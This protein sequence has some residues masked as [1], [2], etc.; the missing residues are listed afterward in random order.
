M[1][2]LE[3]LVCPKCHEPLTTIEAGRELRCVRDGSR[4]P[5]VDG[6]PSFLMTGGDTV[7]L[8]GCALILMIPALNEAAN[9][10]RI[11][12][13]LARALSALVPTNEICVVDGGSTERTPEVGRVDEARQGS[14]TL[15]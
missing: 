7:T 11:L 4:Y 2:S 10:G 13:V 14:Q 1:Q 15:P 9:L 8:A 3:G 6:I 5:L 12:P